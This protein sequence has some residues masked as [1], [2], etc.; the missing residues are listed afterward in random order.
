VA[1]W[2][3]PIVSVV[4]G[5]LGCLAATGALVAATPE[6]RHYRPAVTNEK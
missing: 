2:L 3:G 4:S 6:L 5:G 1:Q